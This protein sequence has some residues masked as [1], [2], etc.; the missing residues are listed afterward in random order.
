M[1]KNISISRWPLLIG[2]LLLLV[3]A[4]NKNEDLVTADAKTGGLVEPTTNFF[5]A[6]GVTTQVDIVINVPTGPQIESI[7]IYNKYILDETTE[8]NEV[9]LATLTGFG[10][11]IPLTYT[12]DQLKTGL[13]LNGLPLPAGDTSLLIGS[14]FIFRYEVKMA[15]GRLLKNVNTT[16]IG[17][18]NFFAGQYQVTGVFHHPT[19]G[20]RAIN[21]KKDLIAIN[22]FECTTT[23]GDL[24]PDYPIK[25]NIDPAT[26]IPVVYAMPGTP[27]MTMTPGKTSSYDPV[28][29][30]IILYY[31]YEG[32]TGTRAMEETYTPL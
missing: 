12:Y 15:D 23:A 19:A 30:I 2:L 11:S 22:A 16:T 28:T 4:C 27:D 10:A 14:S 3:A 32:A 13:L 17:I 31:G 24:A 6:L 20:D 18:S 5:Y 9:L 7:F 8:S 1:K 26:N 21:E 25:I 29:G